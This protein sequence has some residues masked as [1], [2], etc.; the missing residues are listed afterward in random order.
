MIGERIANIRSNMGLNQTDFA[1]LFGVTQT[2]VYTWEKNKNTP[3]PDTLVKIAKHGKVTLD[4]LLTGIE[5]TFTPP[6]I[7]PNSITSNVKPAIGNWYPIVGKVTAGDCQILEDN[8]E[9]EVFMEYHKKN[10]CFA[11][12]VEGNS[13][14]GGDYPICEGDCVLVDP[15]Q[16]PLQG[17][18]IVIIVNGRQMVKRLSKVNKNDVELYSYNSE[19]PIM[20]VEKDNIEKI[21]RVVFHQPRGRKL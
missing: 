20:H 8:A 7:D 5:S 15:D 17:D 1:S 13:M 14:N 16:T 11:V 4:W 12:V 2:A 18:I 6:L 10:G 21:L 9:G 19:F 3:D